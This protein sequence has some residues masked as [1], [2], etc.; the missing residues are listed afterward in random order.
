MDHT[1]NHE[2]ETENTKRQ[3]DNCGAAFK[4]GRSDATAKAR[5]AAPKL[6]GAVADA[7]YDVAYGAAYGVF[8]A[9]AFA[10]EFVPRSVRDVVGKGVAKGAAAGRKAA[11][12]MR[13]KS[14]AANHNNEDADGSL[15]LPA[16]A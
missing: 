4:A 16:P 6:K 11:D 10:N 12:K 15:E 5:E 14:E 3:F 7:V 8:F 1:E 9:G 13:T 2:E